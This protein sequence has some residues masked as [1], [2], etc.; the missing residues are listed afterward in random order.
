MSWL[1]HVISV[2]LVLAAVVVAVATAFSS[3][4]AEY[5]KVVLPAG[6]VVHLPEGTV[7]VFQHDG[8]NGIDFEV[9]TVAGGAPVPV[10]AAGGTIAANGVQRS[11]VVGEHGAIA[12]I[13]V[14][15]DGDYRILSTNEVAGAATLEFGT[16][17]ATALADKWKL[18]A[19]LLF[20]ALLISLIPTPRRT[21]HGDDGNRS[22]GHRDDEMASTSLPPTP[23]RAPYAG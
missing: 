16:N 23:H 11:E 18:F 1:K 19:G 2:A 6:G 5:G 21:R 22:G 4:D 17:A 10:K 20:A 13:D 7:T 15:N 3:H 8:R 9:T 14:P 12:K